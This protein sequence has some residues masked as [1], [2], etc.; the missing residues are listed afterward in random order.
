MAGCVFIFMGDVGKPKTTYLQG[1]DRVYIQHS[2]LKATK[3]YS[4]GVKS[5]TEGAKIGRNQNPDS[6]HQDL[7]DQNLKR[8]SIVC[9]GNLQM[10]SE[11]C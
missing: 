6:R 11:S 8:K 4:L 7:K 9:Y 1:K 5:L 2:K 10:V 3:S